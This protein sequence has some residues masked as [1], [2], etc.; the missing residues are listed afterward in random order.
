[1]M[2]SPEKTFHRIRVAEDDW[3]IVNKQQRGL[4]RID[5]RFSIQIAIVSMHTDRWIFAPLVDV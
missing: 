5:R 3:F 2:M 1:M 4:Y